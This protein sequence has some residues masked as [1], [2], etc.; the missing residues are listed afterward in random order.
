MR[1]RSKINQLL[2]RAFIVTLPIVFNSVL[3]L[4]QAEFSFEEKTHKFSPTKAGALLEHDFEFSNVGN[5]P[6]L[7]DHVSVTC[8]C[9]KCDYTKELI[10]PGE[11]SVI[12]I[13]FDTKDKIDFQNR[14]VS[15]YSNTSK[16]PTKIR[17]KVLITRD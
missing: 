16:N 13:T 11:K 1:Q 14:V 7:I 2:F 10:L 3:A 4:A 5:A 15:I 12:H 6:L 9:T 8:P 17:F